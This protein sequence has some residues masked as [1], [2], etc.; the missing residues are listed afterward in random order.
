ME[1]K[2]A[3]IAGG[4]RIKQNKRH[5]TGI[6]SNKSKYIKNIE[7]CNKKILEMNDNDYLKFRDY[8]TK[9]ISEVCNE[10]KRDNFRDRDEFRKYKE[11]KLKYLYKVLFYPKNEIKIIFKTDNYNFIEKTFNKDG[12]VIIDKIIN[13]LEK[14]IKERAYEPIDEESVYDKDI[15]DTCCLDLGLDVS[16]R[17]LFSKIKNAYNEKK[18]LAGGNDEEKEKIN[19]AFITIRNQ[20]E[21]YLKCTM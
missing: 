2:K 18:E 19:K 10:I 12:L 20:Y 8:S 15:F 11:N 16:E 17:L 14:T 6:V 13:L 7:S 3:V 5:N 21:N 4:R 9:I 1:V